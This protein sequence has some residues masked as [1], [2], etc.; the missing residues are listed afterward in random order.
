MWKKILFWI[1]AIVITLA[2]SKYQRMTGPTYPKKYTLA[3]EENEKSFTLPR[4]HGGDTDCPVELAVPESVDAYILYR[5]YPSTDPFDTLTMIRQNDTLLAALPHQPPAG[6]L[7]YHL[8]LFVNGVKQDLGDRENVIIRFKGAVPLWA[9]IPHILLM[10]L[11]MLWS[12][13]SALFAAAKIASYRRHMSITIL[14]F[15]VGGFVFGPVVQYYAFGDFWTGW[16]NGKDL[17][18]NKVLIS[19]LA[20][21]LAWILNRKKERRWAVIA[22]A[23]VLLA[24]YMIPHSMNGSELDYS[25]GEVVTGALA[26]LALKG[27]KNRS[28]RVRNAVF[29]A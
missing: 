6:K 17:T 26:F 18:D 24:I 27:N 16:P 8:E 15:L 25:S 19:V 29:R 23:L 14:L 7:E 3:I 9:L 2:A 4:S 12:N 5:R 1:L 20:W 13:A 21:G 10:F 11:A 22:A 28:T